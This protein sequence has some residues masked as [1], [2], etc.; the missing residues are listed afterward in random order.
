MHKLTSWCL[1]GVGGLG[2]WQSI[3][4]NA[5][6]GWSQIWQFLPPG[7]NRINLSDMC[8][9]CF[10]RKTGFHCHIKFWPLL[11]ISSCLDA[12]N[13]MAVL[14]T[15]CCAA[16]WSSWHRWSVQ[17]HSDSAGQSKHSKS[18]VLY[19]VT[20]FYRGRNGMT[21]PIV[22]NYDF[23]TMYDFRT[24]RGHRLDFQ[25]M[26]HIDSNAHECT[27]SVSQLNKYKSN[28]KSISLQ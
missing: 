18:L 12:E 10:H 19:I 25:G 13:K 4:R 2:W 21:M 22:D 23:R 8:I 15:V 24:I 3:K 20:G 11:K 5:V 16:A 1:S 7:N 14:R 28:D 6:N 27:A 17:F 26:T 9:G